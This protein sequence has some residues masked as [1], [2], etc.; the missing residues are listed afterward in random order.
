LQGK[1][2]LGAVA[3]MQQNKRLK[4][5]A[6]LHR[7]RAREST[8]RQKKKKQNNKKKKKGTTS[9]TYVQSTS[10]PKKIYKIIK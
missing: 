5:M 7:M 2:T 9:A 10:R 1:C 3:K 8:R 6:P 4:M